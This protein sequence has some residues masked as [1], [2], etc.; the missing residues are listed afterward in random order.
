MKFIWHDGGRAACGFVGQTG[1]CVTRSIAIATGRVYRD[2]YQALSETSS[3]TARHG[4][5]DGVASQYLRALGWKRMTAEKMTPADL[6]PGALMLVFNSFHTNRTG[7]MSCMVDH[8]IY[9]T[10]NPLEDPEY[11]LVEYWLCP[12]ACTDKA[13][14]VP[15]SGR[16]TATESGDLTQKVF[17]KI[18]DRVKALHRTSE[19]DA[20][21]EGEIRNALRMMQTLMLKHNLSRSDIV[22]DD[23]IRNVGFTRR[24]CPLNGRKACQWESM[25]A[26]YMT[27]EVFP[28][29]QFYQSRK[30]GHRTLYWF[31]GAVDDVEQTLELFREIVLTIATTA[32]LKYGGYSRGSGASYAE[33]YVKGLPRSEDY[34]PGDHALVSQNALIHTRM[35]AIHS[36]AN[37]WL[38]RECDIRLHKVSG[39]GRYSFDQHAHD[40][41]RRD[42]ARHHVSGAQRR[43]RITHP[44]RP[45]HAP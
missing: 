2:V 34:D 33:G 21:T 15:A 25:L 36:A 39:S 35:L 16:P 42:G 13:L 22:E 32:R 30:Q 20:S 14:P 3:R 37:D 18:L 10:W 28:T 6:P 9:D 44:E 27:E 41:G 38:E 23:D 29:V 45:S 43:K 7:H 1:D 12:A 40:S 17:D 11:H 31:Y 24:A 19:N 26:F 5:D 8:T 4:I